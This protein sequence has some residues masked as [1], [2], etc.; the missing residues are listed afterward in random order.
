MMLGRTAS[1]MVSLILV[2]FA[3][4]RYQSAAVAGAATFL[5]I[6]PGLLVSPIAGALLDRHGRTRL[7]IVDYVV[8]ATALVLIAVLDS[9]DSLPVP[10]LLHIV[11]GIFFLALPVLSLQ[12][13]GQSP[14]FVGAM[15]SLMGIAAGASVLF[16][17]RINTEGRERQLMAGSMFGQG[18]A[19][20]LVLFAPFV[21]T[22]ALAMLAMGLATG[23]FDVTMFTL[24]QRRTDSA[25]FGRAFAVSMALNFA[26]FP[27]GSAV[28]GVML[29]TSL[30]GALALAVST[31]AAAAAM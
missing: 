25:W 26:G 10:A 11:T 2:L 28:G 17:G 31:A 12:R 21:P 15:F 20:A 5:S 6:A 7:I 16:F 4:D 23:P 18:V 30:G 14:A 27:V 8:A 3:L 13:L 22:V 29:A 1:S 9:A 24:R 19:M